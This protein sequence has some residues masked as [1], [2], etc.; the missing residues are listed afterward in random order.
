MMAGVREV[1]RWSDFIRRNPKI[2]SND[3]YG[4]AAR[5]CFGSRNESC[6]WPEVLTEDRATNTVASGSP[7]QARP[8][9]YPARSFA[10][11]CATD[12]PRT[13]TTLWRE[14]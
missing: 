13:H 4:L 1:R 14:V 8:L 9:S 2:L 10:F 11:T 5:R 7:E 6:T 3:W 12:V